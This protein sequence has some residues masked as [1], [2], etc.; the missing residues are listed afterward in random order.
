MPVT[1][2]GGE[3]ADRRGHDRGPAWPGPRRRPG[4]TTR[5]RTVRRPGWPPRTSRARSAW[6]TGGTNRTTSSSP[7]AWT[8]CGQ[9]LGV[10]QA[11]PGG[12]ADDGTTRRDRRP[13][14]G[15]EQLGHRTEQ[16]VGRLER[17]DPAGEGGTWASAGSPRSARAVAWSSGRKT[18]RSTPG[19]TTSTGRPRRRTGR[20]SCLASMSVLATSMSAAVDHLLLADDP[21]DRLGGVPEREGLAF[22]TLAIVCMVCT[23]G[24]PQRSRARAPTWPESQ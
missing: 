13:A 18:D 22:L 12:T 10:L 9:R 6:A 16:H 17:L 23:S 14:S 5:C 1:D 2:D 21:G 4:R 20:S 3:P 15:L 8:S 11:G 7:S 19:W 24:T